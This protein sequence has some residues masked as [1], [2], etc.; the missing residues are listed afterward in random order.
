MTSVDVKI[1][2]D[3][4]PVPFVLTKPKFVF[5][6]DNVAPVNV[7][8][9]AEPNPKFVRAVAGVETSDKLFAGSSF[10]AKNVRS[11]DDK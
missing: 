2:V 11:A 6:A 7:G 5:N 9:F 8:E 3:K 1:A 10:A 4:T